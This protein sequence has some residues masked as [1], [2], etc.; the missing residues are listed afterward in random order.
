MRSLSPKDATARWAMPMFLLTLL[1]VGLIAGLIVAW[2]DI[3]RLS[4]LHSTVR[5]TDIST[6]SAPGE[7]I[8]PLVHD[9]S[10]PQTDNP[11]T[12][13][14]DTD[15]VARIPMTSGVSKF[16]ISCGI[17]LI[18]IWPIYI[19]EFVLL[20]GTRITG[21]L[22]REARFPRSQFAV[23]LV[24]PLR[25]GLVS[26]YQDNQLWLPRFGWRRPGRQL[27]RDVESVI[28]KPMLIIAFLILPVLLLEYAFDGF[29]VKH[30]WLLVLLH[31]CTG[32]I[33]WCF[34]CEFIVMLA[35]SKRKIQYI[36]KNWLDL[37]IILLPLISFVRSIRVLRLARFAKVQQVTK[38][39]RMYRMRGLLYKAL[40]GLLLTTFIRKLLRISPD[41]TLK[42]LKQQRAV[43]QQ[44]IEDLDQRITQ[45]EDE[46]TSSAS[47]TNNLH[48]DG[49]V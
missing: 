36:K 3:P 26:P 28:S 10:R 20:Y 37:A 8:H 18:L 41:K 33:W 21:W 5:S 25:L 47:M 6:N 34:A 27:I 4:E 40:R 14:T 49:N 7:N 17:L 44:E 23:C 46:I 39:T 12:E 9:S 22:K 32:F 15:P 42:N 43:K 13:N 11:V 2:F 19:I 16:A 1:F 29:L 48:A 38:I 45:I 35:A 24:P 31:A 30:P